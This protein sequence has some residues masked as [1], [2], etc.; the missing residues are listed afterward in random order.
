M[1]EPGPH[2]QHCASANS[3]LVRKCM[4]F[5]QCRYSKATL[6]ISNRQSC[7]EMHGLLSLQM[8][9]WL[10]R[11]SATASLAGGCMGCHCCKHLSPTMCMSTCQSCKEMSGLCSCCCRFASVA[12]GTKVQASAV[13]CLWH[14]LP[15]HTLSG[16]GQSSL[17]CS[18][19]ALHHIK[20]QQPSCELGRRSQTQS[21]LNIF[22]Q[23]Q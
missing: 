3:S 13:Q 8:P 20:Q 6:C 21:K 11:A 7:R 5:R 19:L 17:L 1:P 23:H 12:Q 16:Q 15:A 14:T 2:W 10:Q 4:I 22:A 9:V 18:P